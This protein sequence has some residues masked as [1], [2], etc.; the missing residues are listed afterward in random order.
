LSLQE[1]LNSAARCLPPKASSNDTRQP[2][3]VEQVSAGGLSFLVIGLEDYAE[4]LHLRHCVQR[5]VADRHTP[6]HGIANPADEAS[7]S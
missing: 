7:F 3:G 2:G 6:P 1:E 4:M 5:Q